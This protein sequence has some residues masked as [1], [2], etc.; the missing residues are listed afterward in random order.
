MTPGTQTPRRTRSECKTPP[1]EKYDKKTKTAQDVR[2]SS[3]P[4][5]TSAQ[6]QRMHVKPVIKDLRKEREREKKVIT[7]AEEETRMNLKPMTLI[8]A[9]CAIMLSRIEQ[10]EVL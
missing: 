2:S 5:T 7:T 10:Q 8:V 4:R 6:S 9:I 3:V 1:D